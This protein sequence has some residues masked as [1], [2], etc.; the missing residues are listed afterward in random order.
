[1]NTIP[2]ISSREAFEELSSNAD[3]I[4]VDV[5]T[6]AEWTF[7]GIP[8]VPARRGIFLSWQAYPGMAVDGAF[9][10]RLT[11]ALGGQ[12]ADKDRPLLFLC[13]SGGRSQAAALAMAEAGFTACANVSDGFEGDL[14]GERRRGRVSGWKASGLPWVQS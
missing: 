7:V 13:R 14:D 8:D 1:M 5:R 3:A 12:D 10:E 6:E 11:D 9:I 2:Q 4:L